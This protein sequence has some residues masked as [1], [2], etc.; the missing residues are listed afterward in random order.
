MNENT[1]A[2]ITEAYD[3][4]IAALPQAEGIT[5]NEIEQA[6]RILNKRR[7]EL[8][9]RG[10]LK[11]RHIWAAYSSYGAP[12]ATLPIFEELGVKIEAIFAN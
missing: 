2:Q 5:I 9:A 8:L 4:A 6:E 3:A 11:Q 7:E 1:I 12:Y 10:E